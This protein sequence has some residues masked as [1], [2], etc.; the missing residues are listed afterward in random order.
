MVRRIADEAEK[1]REHSE[2]PGLHFSK[3]NIAMERNRDHKVRNPE[4]DSVRKYQPGKRGRREGVEPVRG[5]S[6]EADTC[7]SC[8]Y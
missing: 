1:E 3:R 4:R 8:G 7:G 2:R 6:T 5:S